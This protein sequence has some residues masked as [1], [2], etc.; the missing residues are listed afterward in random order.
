MSTQCEITHSIGETGK[1]TGA[2]QKQI[3]YWEKKDSFPSRSRGTCAVISPIGG[4]PRIRL[5]GFVPLKDT[6]IKAI[7]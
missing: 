7:L 1:L 6:W 2:S 4:S 5:S 3:R